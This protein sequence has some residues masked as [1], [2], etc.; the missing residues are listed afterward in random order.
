MIVV[1]YSIWI[2][3]IH[4][5]N[6]H[7]GELLLRDDA[8]MHPHVLGEIC[9]GSI[10]NRE[11]V[12]D[13]LLMLPVPNV[14]KEGHLLHMIETEGLSCT[15]IGYTDAHLLASALLSPDGKLWTKNK[16][17]FTQAQ[18]LGVDYNP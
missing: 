3:H 7:L 10:R 17:L 12:I 8:T 18:R 2:D 16:A 15:G 11:V 5:P 13:R 9:L 4:R 14:A 6:P 1:D